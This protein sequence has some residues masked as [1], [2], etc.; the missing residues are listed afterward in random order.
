MLGRPA[1]FNPFADPFLYLIK[2]VLRTK[3]ESTQKPYD[4]FTTEGLAADASDASGEEDT[5]RK[6][7]DESEDNVYSE[8]GKGE[9][10][11]GFERPFYN[12]SQGAFE[13]RPIDIQGACEKNAECSHSPYGTENA[14]VP[15]LPPQV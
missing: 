3:I 4:A 7:D 9:R 2:M 15:A 11:K 14:R 5:E 10:R 6:S 1:I 13:G 12:E 8:G